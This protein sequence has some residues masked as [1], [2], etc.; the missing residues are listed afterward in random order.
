M[1]QGSGFTKVVLSV[2]HLVICERGDEDE[3]GA[4]IILS[5]SA[6]A[7]KEWKRRGGAR[8]DYNRRFQKLLLKEGRLERIEVQVGGRFF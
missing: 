3:L 2:R 1:W 7:A 8:R 6:A 5:V 4:N